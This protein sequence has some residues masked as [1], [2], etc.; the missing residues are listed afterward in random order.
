MQFRADEYYRA[1]LERMRQA[2]AIY[3]SGSSFALAMYVGGLAVECLLR[4]YRWAANPSFE[5]RHDLADLLHAS[6]LLKVDEAHMK[7]KRATDDELT[8]SARQVRSAVQELV[9]LWHNNLRFASEDSA[10]AH[11]RR[12][13]RHRGVKGDPVKK[14]ALD[15]LE[16]A[17][18]IID[19]G[20][21]LWT[22]KAKS[23]RR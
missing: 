8:K 23:R 2:R 9:S 6:E 11:L 4:A 5:G 16:A 7:L 22:S 21:A 13:G 17:Q 19:R 20:A 14:S 18:T 15:L 10:K 3:Q 1:S 12:I